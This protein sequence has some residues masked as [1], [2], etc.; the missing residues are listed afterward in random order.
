MKRPPTKLSNHACF[1]VCKQ[2]PNLLLIA[3]V[4]MGYRF[5]FE[6]IK[7]H[8]IEVSYDD[9][10]QTF[11]GT[12]KEIYKLSSK[13]KTVEMEKHTMMPKVTVQAFSVPSAKLTIPQQKWA[14]MVSP[15]LSKMREKEENRSKMH[16]T[17]RRN[18]YDSDFNPQ[19]CFHG[20][21]TRI[22]RS[23]CGIYLS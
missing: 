17:I 7:A 21:Q 15:H 10:F 13:F 22:Y 12:G 9:H 19:R 3:M 8:D 16:L 5:F 18:T 14:C 6:A 11:S 20:S 2:H 1:L 4:G 23:I